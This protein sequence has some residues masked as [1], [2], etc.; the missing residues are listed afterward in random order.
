MTTFQFDEPM[1][2]SSGIDLLIITSMSILIIFVNGKYLNDMNE[3][4]KTRSPGTPPCLISDVMRARTK[5]GM[6]VLPFYYLLAWF[7]SQGFLLPDWFYHMVCN[8]Q[9][10]TLYL[11]FYFSS[12][13][14][15][16]SL[17]RYVFIVHNRKVLEFGKDEAKALFYYASVGVPLILASLHALTIPVPL[18]AYNIPHRVCSLFHENAYN[19]TC[20]DPYGV[21]DECSPVLSFV[22]QHVPTDVTVTIGIMVKVLYIVTCTNVLDGILYWKTFKMIRE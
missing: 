1:Y 4:D 10:L 12:T 17:M 21:K 2:F 6:V 22:L 13:S 5:T 9:Y 11:R 16:I 8:E 14:L 19:L 3:D 18:S 7:L 20:G 15:I